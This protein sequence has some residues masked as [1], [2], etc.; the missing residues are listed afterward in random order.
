MFLF[1]AVSP[2]FFAHYTKVSFLPLIRVQ[3]LIHALAQFDGGV[4]VVSHDE[5]LINAVCDELWVLSDKKVSTFPSANWQHTCAHLRMITHEH[6]QCVKL[7]KVAS[8]LA[9]TKLQHRMRRSGR[10]IDHV[11]RQTMLGMGDFSDYKRH[12]QKQ[13][14]Y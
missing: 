1:L 11:V 8:W 10:H 5:Y 14:K 9:T 2:A 12:V 7:L 6:M 13:M 4:L 3:A